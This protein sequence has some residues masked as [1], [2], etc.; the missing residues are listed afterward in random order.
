MGNQKT[1]Y[2]PKPNKIQK[3]S[4]LGFFK[5]PGFSEPWS[6]HNCTAVK[7]AGNVI[8][9]LWTLFNFNQTHATVAGN[10]QSF[11]IAKS[12]NLYAGYGT[13]LHITEC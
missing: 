8:F 6:E 9:Y 11:M 1:Q 13:C 3:P 5:N 4:G 2:S 12:W 7:H 10:R